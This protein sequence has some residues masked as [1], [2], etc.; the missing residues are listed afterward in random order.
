VR[1][2]NAKL[3]NTLPLFDE[4][5]KSSWTLLNRDW[6]FKPKQRTLSRRFNNFSTSTCSFVTT[7]C[8]P[9]YLDTMLLVTFIKSLKRSRFSSF[10]LFELIVLRL[11]LKLSEVF[12]NFKTDSHVL[13]RFN[14]LF[15][16][17]VKAI[18]FQ[19]NSNVNS[20]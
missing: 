5:E 4:E 12:R 3:Q 9:L 2:W 19:I 11:L 7:C 6:F 16:R 17:E 20:C 13:A 15:E 10:I 14:P 1:C 18:M 8:P